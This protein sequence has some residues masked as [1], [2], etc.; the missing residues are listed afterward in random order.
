VPDAAAMMPPLAPLDMPEQSLHSGRLH[1]RRLPTTPR[2]MG[3]RRLYLFGGAGL[4]TALACYLMLDVLMA[5]GVSVLDVLLLVLY[6]ALFGWIALAFFSAMAGFCVMLFGRHRRL[7]IDPH[8][9]LPVLSTRTALLMPTYNEDPHRV[10]AG[11]EAIRESL[12]ATGQGDR[13]DFFVLSDTTRPGIAAEELQAVAEL[14]GRLSGPVG[15][16]YRHRGDNT[17]RKAGNIAGWVREHG[18]AY[19]Q[20][21]I[22]DAD[23]LMTGECIVRLVAGVEAHPDVAL[24]QSLPVV[25]NGTTLFAR[26]Q[27]FGGRVYGPVIAHGVAWWHGAESNYWGHNAV[28]RTR[29]FAECAG[30]PTLRG[31]KPFGGHILSHDFVEAALMRRGGWALH[32]VPTLTGSYE[33]GPPSLTDL[34]IRDRRWCQ[35][36]LQH[37]AVLPSTGLHWLSRW[38]FGSGMFHYFTSPMWALT[39]LIG[40]AIPLDDYGWDPHGMR[41]PGFSPGDYWFGRDHHLAAWLFAATMAVLLAP[42]VMGYVT[43]LFDRDERRGC[44]G[45]IRLRQ[46]A[47][48]NRA[49][50]VDGADHD[51]RA[52]ARG[53]AGA[54]RPRLGL[55]CAA[56]DDGG[57]PLKAGAAL[58][59][60]EPV[61]PVLR[62]HGVGGVARA[63]RVDGAG[64]AGHGDLDPA[65]GADL[66]ARAG[67]VVAPASVAVH[68]GGNHAAADP[69]PCPPPAR[70]AGRLSRVRRRA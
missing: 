67:T 59:R 41:L 45:A 31:G 35:G 2:G 26:M 57:L 1:N 22:L 17:G 18:A 16:Y 7:G 25:I 36:N 21:L 37:M 12:L 8:A 13:F 20:F 46:H 62:R 4:M 19:P 10:L 50:G 60:A 33:E 30:L 11:L 48:G 52:V 9:P 39:L 56:R 51:V 15:L 69:A 61:R 6:V 42:K 23:S 38:H 49:G 68:A 54:G 47:A 3:W 70:A 44:G 28:I 29:A 5:D 64:G 27:Q 55:G 63:G 43:M 65:G 53:G 14:R 34:L 66:G 58:R 40:I 24:V 32:M